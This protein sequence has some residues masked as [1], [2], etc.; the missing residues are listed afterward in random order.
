MQNSHYFEINKF[1]SMMDFSCRAL[2]IH[3]L[4]GKKFQTERTFQYPNGF[5]QLIK[6]AILTMTI[7]I[8]SLPSSHNSGNGLSPYQLNS[9]LYLSSSI[10]SLL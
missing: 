1:K 6:K 8:T 2:P 9:K 3:Y 4:H 7:E 5:A 10:F